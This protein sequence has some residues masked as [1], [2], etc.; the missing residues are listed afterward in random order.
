MIDDSSLAD[1]WIAFWREKEAT[2]D[3][4]NDDRSS[5]VDD[6]V[7]ED[8][9]RAWPVILVILERIAPDPASKSFQLLAAGPLEDLLVHHGSAFIDRI[10]S[11]ARKRPSF[12]LL[13][14]GVW[15]ST[16]DPAI[17]QRVEKYRTEVW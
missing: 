16:T 15:P 12:R 8:P 5:D 11:E 13:L 7:R 10:E 17:W 3:I 9:E 2:G 6:L 14:C 1:G 4:P